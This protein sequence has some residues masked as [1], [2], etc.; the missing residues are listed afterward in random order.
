MKIV[1]YLARA[2]SSTLDRNP[3]L[4]FWLQGQWLNFGAFVLDLK[5]AGWVIRRPEWLRVKSSSKVRKLEPEL[6]HASNVNGALATRIITASRL[7]LQAG[8]ASA[9][10]RDTIWGSL[11]QEQYSELRRLIELGNA[12]SLACFQARIFRTNTVNGYT[13]GTTFDGWPH[14]W[15]YVPVQIELSVVQLAESLGIIRAECH[16]QGETAFWRLL[17]SEEELMG[18]IEEFFGFRIEQ[19]RVGD[20][21]GIFF[22]GRFLT[23]ETCSHLYSAHRMRTAI[24]RAGIMGPLNIVEI[25]GGFGGTCF[26][27]RKLLRDRVQHYAIVDLPEVGLVQA[28][29]L[30]S[31]EPESLIIRGEK[32]PSDKQTIELIPHFAVEDIEF[33]PNVIIN[34]DSMPEMPESEVE[35]YLEWASRRLKGIFLSFNQEAYSPFAGV[36][37]VW[38]PEIAARHPQLR[39]VSRDT[40]WDRRGY[41]EEVYK[42][43]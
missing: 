7:V 4:M 38:V 43:H 39:R 41:V 15:H 34:Q 36:H 26:W 35:R 3:S 25:G 31:L 30:G 22:G 20:P 19:P 17:I 6:D 2:L 16:E 29:F 37:Q 12:E 28:Y 21:R 10:A 27:L 14:R 1:K 11:L 23:R 33:N 8:V 42:T 13:Y 40:S 32:R 24:E 5:M 18:K 9:P